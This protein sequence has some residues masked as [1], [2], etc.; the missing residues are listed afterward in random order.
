MGSKYTGITNTERKTEQRR[1]RN[2]RWAT[3][4]REPVYDGDEA[5]D[6]ALSEEHRAWLQEHLGK[7][8]MYWLSGTSRAHWIFG[9]T[10]IKDKELER[11]GVPQ[12]GSMVSR[13]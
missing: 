5:D 10:H 2:E 8:L 9:V 11:L 1:S 4:G 13:G 12:D 3:A 6:A 7:G